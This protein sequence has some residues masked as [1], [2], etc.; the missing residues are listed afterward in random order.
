MAQPC[1]PRTHTL[2]IV[3][4]P[5]HPPFSL[6]QG[7]GLIRHNQYMLSIL[8]FIAKCTST[9]DADFEDMVA[10]HGLAVVVY[11]QPVRAWGLGF[12]LEGGAGSEI[13]RWRCSVE[14][15]CWCTVASEGRLGSSWGFLL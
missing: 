13:W 7:C 5:K 8:T 14:S 10:Q 1:C 15:R 9:S 2:E 6:A 3:S 4:L 11:N 12:G